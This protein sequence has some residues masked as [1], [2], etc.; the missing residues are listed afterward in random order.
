MEYYSGHRALGNEPSPKGAWE[1]RV[2]TLAS[3][4]SEWTPHPEENSTPRD[5]TGVWTLLTLAH[6]RAI[7]RFIDAYEAEESAPGEALIELREAQK[8]LKVFQ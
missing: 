6:A 3:D 2:F 5:G 7:T 4:G 1:G 8:S